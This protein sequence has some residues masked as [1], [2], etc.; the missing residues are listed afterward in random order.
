MLSKPVQ[1]ISEQFVSNIGNDGDGCGC[2]G[3]HGWLLVIRGASQRE[4]RQNRKVEY[5]SIM[6][7]S[8]TGMPEIP[9]LALSGAA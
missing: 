1:M 8:P 3:S 4:K 9:K 6:P 5:L 2:I 7:N